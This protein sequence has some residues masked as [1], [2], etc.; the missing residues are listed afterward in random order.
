MG[1]LRSHH[2]SSQIPLSVPGSA[3]PN[4][5]RAVWGL[6][7]G[8]GWRRL[9][10]EGLAVAAAA[11]PNHRSGAG[12]SPPGPSGERDR[13]E[14]LYRPRTSPCLESHHPKLQQRP[15]IT[16]PKPTLQVAVS[17]K[18]RL[19]HLNAAV[20]GCCPWLGQV[21]TPALSLTHRDT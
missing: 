20:E 15:Q 3:G 5:R 6:A 14:G 21:N 8:S 1:S 12:A 19:S 16:C 7:A 17:V 2:D 18:S 11:A 13:G 4:Q 9:H 10:P